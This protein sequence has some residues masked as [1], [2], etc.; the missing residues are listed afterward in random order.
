MA[1]VNVLLARW[2]QALLYNAGGF[3]R[4]FQS[5]RLGRGLAA[6]TIVMALVALAGGVSL[7]SDILYILGACY[8]LQGMAVMHALSKQVTIHRLWTVSLYVLLV[9]MPQMMLLVALLGL[10][11]SWA[12]FRARFAKKN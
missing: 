1:L 3:A 10:L 6:A 9:L 8:F 7:A 2:W 5:L 4:E 11:D 12:D